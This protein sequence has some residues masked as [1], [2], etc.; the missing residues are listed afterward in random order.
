MDHG[1]R[2]PVHFII[3]KKSAGQYQTA[4]QS[5]YDVTT[6]AWVLL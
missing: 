4:G 2:L 3:H 1:A 5:K 6:F